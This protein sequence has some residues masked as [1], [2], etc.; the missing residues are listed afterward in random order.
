MLNELVRHYVENK[1]V[2]ITS[3]P[4]NGCT[5][6]MLFIANLLLEKKD[7][8]VL[9]FDPLREIE[10]SFVSTYYKNVYNDCVFFYGDLE[11]FL[12]FI[13]DNSFKFDYIIID[14][15]DLLLVNNNLL[16][17]IIKITGSNVICTSQI[18]ND[19]SAGGDIYSTIE[20]KYLAGLDYSIWIR[21]V[22]EP[23]S[24][25]KTK[26]LD[27]YKGTHIGNNFIS[28]YV[29]KFRNNGSIVEG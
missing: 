7:Y 10:K 26:Y 24:L 19:L 14:P 21:N 27:I 13:F 23:Y 12:E 6:L 8:N 1:N 20:R 17:D 16:P 15:A 5:S 22:T 9:I 11:T 4:G 29:A 25:Y 3:A 2:I 18:R 28:R